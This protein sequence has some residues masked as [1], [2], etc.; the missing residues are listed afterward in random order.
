[1]FAVAAVHS[2]GLLVPVLEFLGRNEFVY[3]VPAL[4]QESLLS[5]FKPLSAAFVVIISHDDLLGL[6]ALSL[7]RRHLTALRTGGVVPSG[8]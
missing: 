3:A 2:S 5:C 1:M 6:E 7:D 4:K 8:A